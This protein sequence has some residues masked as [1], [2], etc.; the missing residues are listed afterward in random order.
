MKFAARLVQQLSVSALIAFALAPTSTFAQSDSPIRIL[1]GF[2]P[3]GSTDMIARHLALGLQRELGRPVVVDNKPG[4]GGQIAAQAL[5]Q[6][7]PDGLTIFLSNSHAISMIPLTVR[8]PG[9]DPA[10]DFSPIALVALIPDV[11]VV[12]T[13]GVPGSTQSLKD[14]AAWAKANP[15]KGNVGVPAPA[16]APDFAVSMISAEISAQLVSV[17]YRGE[18]PLIQD[19]IAGQ[20]PAGI[21]S[22]A[23]MLPAAKDGK[24]RIVAINGMARSPSLPDVPTYGELGIAGYETVGFTALYAPAGT[25]DALVKAYAAAASKVV[26]SKDFSEKMTALGATAVQGAPEDVKKMMHAADA[27]FASMVKRT[28]FQPQ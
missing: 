18:A 17:P 7:K 22:I 26:G 5:K 24:I 13:R 21:G 28:G 15:G 3:G 16:S 19:L 25:S 8:Q 27:S 10:K 2:S 9:Y 11:L 1:V 20:I 14:F 23:A 6:A 12:S 4:A